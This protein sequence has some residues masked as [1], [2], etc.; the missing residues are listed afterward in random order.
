MKRSIEAVYGD[1]IKKLII[2]L[3]EYDRVNSAKAK[4]KFCG[5]VITLDNISIIFPESGDIK[6]VCSSRQCML[7]IEPLT[8]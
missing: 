2:Q 1:E 3:G 7:K 8:R 4:C 5:K 6:Y